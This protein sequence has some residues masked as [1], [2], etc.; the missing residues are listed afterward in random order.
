MLVALALAE[1]A[2]RPLNAF[3]DADMSFHY[4]G[5][6]GVLL[7]VIA[8]TLLV[9]LAGGAY[10]AF[11][12]SRFEPAR[13]LKANKSAADAQGSGRLRGLLVIAQFAVSIGLIICTAVIYAQTAYARSADAGYRREGMIQIDN[14]DRAQVD[15]AMPSLLERLRVTP[16]IVDAARVGI[17]IATGNNSATDVN[18]PGQPPV[19]LG[20]YAADSHAFT[21][22]GVPVLAGRVLSDANPMDDSTTPQPPNAALERAFVARGTNVVVSRLAAER[23]GFRS[24][25][26]AV[27][28]PVQLLMASAE[29]GPITATI[30]GVVADVRYRTARDPVQPILYFDKTADFSQ[31]LVRFR[32]NPNIA[33]ATLERLWKQQLPDVPLRVRFVQDIVHDMYTADQK[34]ATLFAAFALLAVVI[35]CLG[36]FGLAAFTAERRTK[37]IGVRKVLGARTRDIV[38]LLVWQFSRPVLVANLVAWPVA[39]WIMRGWLNGFDVRIALTPLPFVLAGVLAMLI[40]V[41]TVATHA[42]RIAR[43]SPITALRYE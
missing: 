41:L 25:A 24:A 32:G 22:L 14:I 29:L 11:A 8:L 7:P 3:L 30:V 21:T 34:R 36:L 5:S 23:L 26:E 2:I 42:Y 19:T 28:Q 35:G 33:G 15:M 27:G 13:I 39:W 4:W 6:G 40:A 16:G 43:T 9:G 37:E 12:L 1:L 31:L 18:R 10:P 38:R 20:I 17:G